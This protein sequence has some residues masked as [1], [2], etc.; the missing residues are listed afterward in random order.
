[1]KTIVNMNF[2]DIL[3]ALRDGVDEVQ[4]EN[5]LLNTENEQLK[6]QIGNLLKV[7]ADLNNKIQVQS[8]VICDLMHEHDDTCEEIEWVDP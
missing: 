3:N 7:N 4:D 6:K 2:A 1:M 8:D 5:R